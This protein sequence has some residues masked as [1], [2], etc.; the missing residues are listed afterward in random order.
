MLHS[1]VEAQLLNN[2]D[3]RSQH[4]ADQIQQGLQNLT[5]YAG[6]LAKNDLLIN[7][8]ID[9][10]GR[11]GYLPIF[12]HSL[13]LPVD[14][15]ASAFLVDYKG[16][17]IVSSTFDA[18]LPSFTPVTVGQ[19][20]LTLDPQG[21]VIIEPVY[22]HNLVEGAIV[23]YYPASSFSK[24][25][26]TSTF[27]H[28]FFLINSTGI[29]T[30]ST[31]TNLAP[32]NQPEPAIPTDSWLQVRT[33]LPQSGLSVV[34]ASSLYIAFKPLEA[35]QL[36]LLVGLLVFLVISIGLVVMS[37][38]IVSRP[39]KSIAAGISAI[40]KV[41]DL[42]HQLD[43]RGPN[44][45]AEIATTFNR[46]ANW[47]RLTMVSRDHMDNILESVTEG[48]ITIDNKGL[49]MT[50]NIAAAKMFGY[51]STD[52]N[53][54]NISILV[55]P[56]QREQHHS[57]VTNT[58]IHSPRVIGKNRHMQG[59]RRNGSL[60]S[61][62]LVVTRLTKDAESGFVG[63]IRDIT[64]RKM[65]EENLAQRSQ[66]LQR[67]N[68]ELERF[69]YVAS[70]DLKAPMR[71][72]DNLATMIEE[73]FQD[74][75]DEDVQENLS[76]LRGRVLRMEDLLDGLLE[77]SRIGRV[78]TRPETIDS[79]QIVADIV[80]LLALPG[81]FTVD[82]PK[83]IP[84]LSTEKASFEQVMR[85]LINNAVKHHDR[86]EGCITISGTKSNGT[87][88]FSIS[89]D[90]PGI[91]SIFHER[92]FRMFQTLRSRD[93]VEGSGMGLALV[94]KEVELHG[95]SV[96]IISHSE[97]RGTTFQFTWKEEP[98][99]ATDLNYALAGS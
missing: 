56:D 85:N 51:E 28:D 71:G 6:N 59:Y 68:A 93:Q 86:D 67:T 60:F 52:L 7:G 98:E 11:M 53:G 50:N 49:I 79:Q 62:E 41:D 36:V 88:E 43:T 37:V 76:L 83:P 72:I 17:S 3:E 21:L 58:R 40:K 92:V 25:F 34:V 46:M 70:H 8:L 80:D 95:G 18:A 82:I 9:F 65:I 35:V 13:R 12:F 61:M 30:Y 48:I 78:A 20:S 23:L 24:L 99:L 38:F 1:I 94:K 16:R 39:L 54:Q 77:Y 19:Q 10:E 81:G 74:N 29:V 91:D 63:T 64:E 47:L 31:D 26:G 97:R 44:E 66:E 84:T 4:E 45:I 87:C 89:D 15:S 32:V 90:G 27:R 75:L 69:V 55:P 57:Y 73:D 5:D 14:S 96:H 42:G 2:I 22:V 33:K